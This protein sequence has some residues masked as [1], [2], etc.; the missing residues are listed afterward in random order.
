MTPTVPETTHPGATTARTQASATA[1]AVG[2]AVI[3]TCKLLIILTLWALF[4]NPSKRTDVT[5]ESISD[6]LLRRHHTSTPT[7][8]PPAAAA[9]PALTHPTS[10]APTSTPKSEP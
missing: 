3:I 9:Q 4:F 10:Q 8:S 7:V 2:L 5:P 6:G 1:P